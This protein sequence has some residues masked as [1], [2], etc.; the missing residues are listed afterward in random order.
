M[1]MK[2]GGKRVIKIPSEFAYGESGA[3][4][5]IPP[6]STLI[7]EVEIVRIQPPGYL[8]IESDKLKLMQ[9]EG[10]LVIDIRTLKE[11][12]TTGTIKGSKK[13]AAFDERG[14]FIPSFLKSYQSIANSTSKV[15]FISNKGDISAILA[16]GFVEQLGYKNMYSLQGGIQ[17]WISQGNIVI[18]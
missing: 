15:V 6:N 18:K 16:N 1:N 3:G 9:K 12:R 11:M 13:I 5:L 14:N 2:V 17:E 10:F 8:T 4:E 7:F